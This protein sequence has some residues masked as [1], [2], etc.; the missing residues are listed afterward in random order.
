MIPPCGPKGRP[1]THLSTDCVSF[2]GSH[3]VAQG[4]IIPPLLS[5]LRACGDESYKYSVSP[6]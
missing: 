5:R 6:S 4:G 1:K 3:F 2:S